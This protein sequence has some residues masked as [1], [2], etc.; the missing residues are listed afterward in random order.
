MSIPTDT[1]QREA[2]SIAHFPDRSTRW[3]FQF[4]EN[5][6]ALME[7]IAPELADA[8]DFNRLTALNRTFISEALR[9]QESDIVY[10]APFQE[11][12]DPQELIIYILIE[13]QSQVDPTM[14]F[15][16]LSYMMQLWTEQRQ[17]W[18]TRNLPLSQ[19][20]LSAILPV[21]FYTGQQQWT[22]PLSLRDIMDIPES[23]SRFVPTFET[24]FLSVKETSAEA[25]L[26][27]DYPFGWLLTVLQ[28]EGGDVASLTGAL[29]A[30]LLRLEAL[31]ESREAERYRVLV[32]LLHLILHRHPAHE[33]SDLITI[34]KSHTQGTE[35]ELM[36]QSMAEVLIEQGL[37]RGKAEGIEQGLERGKAEGIEQGIEQGAKATTIESI[38]LFL[39][40]RFQA[41]TAETL[42]SPLEAIDD[43]QRLKHLLREATQ[44][45]T[46]DAFITNLRT[47]GNTP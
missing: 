17:E 16:V 41:N 27:T 12:G 29:L 34:V 15:R 5:V 28:Q 10:R 43:L 2:L 22:V 37:E 30:A 7:L 36:A 38:L 47:N 6:H 18:E 44:A 13:H 26:A 31:D 45:K 24:L 40:T 11:A 3:L 32:Y 21:V 39:D 20:R 1:H 46:L 25:L 33:H 8:I 9:E 42:K 14:G 35:V 4:T 23:L 19:R